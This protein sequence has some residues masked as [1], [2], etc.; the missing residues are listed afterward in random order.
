MRTEEGINSPGTGVTGRC[1]PPCRFWDLNPSLRQEQP[2]LLMSE[3]S[4]LPHSC[5][6]TIRTFEFNHSVGIGFGFSLDAFGLYWVT[7]LCLGSP[8][9][10]ASVCQEVASLWPENRT[11]TRGLLKV[12]RD[13][14]AGVFCLPWVVAAANYRGYNYT[15]WLFLA[16]KMPF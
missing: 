16:R 12:T 4:L 10:A 6:F 8:S 2:E 1:E 9:A 13:L 11:L 14:A 3:S 15:R 7:G 5:L